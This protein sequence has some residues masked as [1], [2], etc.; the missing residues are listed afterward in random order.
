MSFDIEDPADPRLLKAHAD[1]LRKRD[2]DQLLGICEFALQD[3]HVD[4]GE[5]EA[6][7]AWLNNHRACVD[8]WPA[9]VLYDRLQSML[10]DGVLDDSEQGELLSLVMSIVRPRAADGLAVAATLPV[11][12]PAPAIVFTE[13]TFC[14]TGVFDFG[15][16]AACQAA[17]QVR[18]GIAADGISKKLHYLVIGN[19]GSEVWRHTS[20][21][22][23]IAKAIEYRDSGLPLVI[24]SEA[25]WAQ[26]L[27]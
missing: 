12:D 10:L 6:I 21:G 18:G 11:N 25:H 17:I 3:G 4:Q 2:I 13:R 20:F 14:F 7:L 22:N 5:A 23:K 8:T 15:T 1:R 9:N 24:V 27:A 26:Q 16:R 19:I